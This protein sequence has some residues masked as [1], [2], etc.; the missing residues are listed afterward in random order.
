M[1]RLGLQDEHECLICCMQLRVTQSF[2]SYTIFGGFLFLHCSHS[3]VW[4]AGKD[5]Y[6][7]C[8][9][10][11]TFHLCDS[12]LFCAACSTFDPDL[13]DKVI[14]TDTSKGRANM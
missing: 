8:S 10:S 2:L 13:S 4:H 12:A 1:V 14:Q 5:R 7:L 6:H 9:C 11:H 3:V